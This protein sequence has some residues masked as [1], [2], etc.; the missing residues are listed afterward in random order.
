[1]KL[2]S[3]LFSYE[4]SIF[5]KFPLILKIINQEPIK[6]KEL[7]YQVSRH[8]ESPAEFIE[9]LDALYAL[10]RVEF[11]EESEELKYVD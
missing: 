1:M 3:K 2:P 4:E 6:V 8:F 5:P 11:N 9:T 10:N 7:Y